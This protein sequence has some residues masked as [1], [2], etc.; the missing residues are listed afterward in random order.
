MLT[1]DRLLQAGIAPDE[2]AVLLSPL[3]PPIV[4]LANQVVLTIA[5]HPGLT[6]KVMHGWKSVNFR[7]QLV[8][9]ICAVFPHPD[10]VMV[11]FEHGILLT[12]GAGVL[13]GNGRRTRHLTLDPTEGVPVDLIGVLLAEAVAIFA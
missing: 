8:G 7:H 2:L 3:A 1:Q 13:A 9:L 4:A 12:N 6:G 5:G 11:Y 10:R